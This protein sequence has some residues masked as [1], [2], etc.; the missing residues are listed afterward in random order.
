MGV[1][2]DVLLRRS[3]WLPAL[4]SRSFVT[5]LAFNQAAS[6]LVWSSGIIPLVMATGGLLL[7]GGIDL[8]RRSVSA[9]HRGA[10]AHEARSCAPR[11]APSSHYGAGERPRRRRPYADAVATRLKR[12][13]R[14]VARAAQKPR[15]LDRH[16]LAGDY[17][18]DRTP[19]SCAWPRSGADAHR[20]PRSPAG[21]VKAASPSEARTLSR[22]WCRRL[23]N[24]ASPTPLIFAASRVDS[25]SRSR[26][27]RAVR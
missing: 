11:S 22:A 5:A 27:T 14:A 1:P 12:A 2:R 10:A 4:R 8:H 9:Q 6:R 18:E 23:L 15:R 17:P 7:S 13:V 21:P 25:P 3:C 19:S 20:G 26:S 16:M 24:A